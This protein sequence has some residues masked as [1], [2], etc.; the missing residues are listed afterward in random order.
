V[1]GQ[2]RD[3]GH[4]RVAH[5]DIGERSVDTHVFRLADG[6]AD[7]SSPAR[8]A[9]LNEPLRQCLID[10][11]RHHQKRRRCDREG[12]QRG[13]EPL[14]CRLI[15][16][17]PRCTHPLCTLPLERRS[18]THPSPVFHFF[19]PT[20][21]APSPKPPVQRSGRP[22]PVVAIAMPPPSSVGTL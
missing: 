2:R 12:G 3:I 9:D 21:L 16:S 22:R 10:R 11:E 4:F 17:P 13:G 6:D 15:V 5:R 14:S 8:T 7:R 20:H 19:L 18:A 1:I